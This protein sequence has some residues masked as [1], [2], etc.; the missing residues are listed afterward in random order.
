MPNPP[1]NSADQASPRRPR[2][3]SDEL[4][5]QILE[6]ASEL[7]LRDGYANT[8]IDAVI[9]KVGGSK[10]AIY[11]HFG[12]K[13]D[14]FAAMVTNLSEAALQA[15]PDAGEDVGN[16]V[17]ASLIRF[18]RAVMQVLMDPRTVAVYRLVVSESGRMPGLANAFLKNGSGRAASGLARLLERYAAA[19]V[20]TLANPAQAAEHFIGMLRDDSHLEVVLGVRPPLTEREWSP[21]VIQAVDIFLDG[22]RTTRQAS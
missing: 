13:D 10:R 16:D 4:R 17:R 18:A 14:L 5:N 11:S 7:F 8:S 19:G 22:A 15:I 21:R 2:R 9:E 6:A 20:V 12:G 1:P 3:S